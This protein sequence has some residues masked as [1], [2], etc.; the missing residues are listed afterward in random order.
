MCLDVYLFVELKLS[1]KKIQEGSLKYN[2][3]SSG[4]NVIL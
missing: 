2:R 4:E 1:N 3:I